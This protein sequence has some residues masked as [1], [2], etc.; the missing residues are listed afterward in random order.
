MR[1]L[2]C[3]GRNYRDPKRV[4]EVLSALQAEHKFNVVITGGAPGADSAALG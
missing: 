1:I 3:G 4:R 2:V